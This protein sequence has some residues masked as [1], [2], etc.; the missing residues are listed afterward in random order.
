MYFGVSDA[1]RI[2]AVW[3]SY[4]WAFNYPVKQ[5]TAFNAAN[6]YSAAGSIAAG[7]P[8]PLP[9]VIPDSGVIP[10]APAQNYIS[11]P[12]DLR[13][14]HLN[15]WNI[16]LQRQLPGSFAF[17][18][19]YVGNY[20]VGTLNNVNINAGQVPGQGAAGQP[21]NI[22]FGLRSAV[23]RWSRFSQTYNGLQVKLDRRYMQGLGITTA[24]TFSKGINYADDN[25][26]LAIPINFAMNRG[27]MGQD[28]T[29]RYVQSVNYELPVGTGRRWLTSGWAGNLLGGW[30]ANG[31]LSIYSGTPVTFSYSATGLNA[32]GNSQRANITGP[33]RVLGDIGPGRKWFDTTTFSIPAAATFGNAGRNTLS[34]PGYWNLDLSLSK[35]FNI[36]ERFRAE[37]RGEAFNLTNTP[38]FNNPTSALDSTQFGEVRSAFG[39]RQIQLGIKLLF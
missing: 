12:P 10:N 16:A 14:G 3:R 13:Q 18:A 21:L 37:L 34:G 5:N 7:F 15:T 11:L 38:H 27:R 6:S 1:A 32:P 26:G 4:K 9:V 33:I 28:R 30:Q 23:T 17:E 20:T 19:A 25:G 36:T 31:T 24:Y 8:A 2:A 22:K 39:E 29:H 35:R